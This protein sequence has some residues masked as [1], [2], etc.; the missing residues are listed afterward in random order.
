MQGMMTMLCIHFW[1]QSLEEKVLREVLRLASV[2]AH[3][4]IAEGAVEIPPLPVEGVRANQRHAHL[5]GASLHPA[6]H[7]CA[8]ALAAV[9]LVHE[10]HG[11]IQDGEGGDA[12]VQASHE[13]S[14]GRQSQPKLSRQQLRHVS[15][16]VFGQA[17]FDFLCLRV[18]Q[19]D[20]LRI[21]G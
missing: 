1:I 11:R 19:F 17:I 3:F 21:R 16:V 15:A 20:D 9:R 18:V 2:A 12:G 13:A 8:E 5:A 6:D 4:L 10:Y 7:P 14:V